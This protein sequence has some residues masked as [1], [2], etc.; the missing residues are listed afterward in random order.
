MSSFAPN[1]QN[2]YLATTRTRVRWEN[3]AII[4]VCAVLA[5]GAVTYI[6]TGD[7]SKPTTPVE[8]S[9]DAAP[10]LPEPALTDDASAA[11]EGELTFEDSLSMVDEARSLMLDARWDDADDRL[12]S[13]PEQFRVDAEADVVAAD[14]TTKRERWAALGTKLEEQVTASQWEAAAKTLVA[15]TAIARLDDDQLRTKELVDANLA[16]EEAPA[17]AKAKAKATK[18]EAAKAEAS[19]T[20][21][22]KPAAVTGGGAAAPAT[23]PVAKP[24]KKPAKPAASAAKPATGGGAPATTAT[25]STAQPGLGD[26]GDLGLGDIDEAALDAALAEALAG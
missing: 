11:V 6:M 1:P 25:P 20:E 9:G 13:V 5:A 23:K 2:P 8:S 10:S 3:I 19:K 22:A 16:P 21:A 24:A 15:L 14:L 12:T 26:L 18:A 4:L 7:T 17:K